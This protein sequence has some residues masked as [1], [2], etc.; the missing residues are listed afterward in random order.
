MLLLLGIGAA[1]IGATVVFGHPA[2][3]QLYFLEAARPCLSVAAVCGVVA[4]GRVPWVRAGCLAVVGAGAA[5][6]VSGAGGVPVEARSEGSGG[7]LVRVVLPY[8]VLGIGALLVWRRGSVLTVVAV[9]AGYALPSSVRDVAAHVTPQA[10][11]RERL[12]P[13]GALEAGRWLRAHSEPGDVVATDLHCRYAWWQ[14]CDSRHF[15][16]SGFSERRVLVEGWAYAEST[17]SRARPF[18]RSYLAVP[19]ADRARLAANEVVFVA[20]TAENVRTLGREYGVKWLFTGINPV[21]GKYA[22]LRFRNGGSSVYQLP[23][24]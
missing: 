7:V 17:L 14:V 18:V 4:A 24:R 16:V 6:V 9:L 15:W 12:I 22:R 21:L 13:G 8:L 10:E 11:Q 1:G 19:F 2:E 3:S 23:G 5:L 20:P